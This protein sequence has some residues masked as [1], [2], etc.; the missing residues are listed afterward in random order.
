MT[1]KQSLNIRM[2][3]EM[4]RALDAEAAKDD[5]PVTALVRKIITDWLRKQ[6]GK[7]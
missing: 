2:E 1:T 5:R 7:R 6:A 3:P 4:R